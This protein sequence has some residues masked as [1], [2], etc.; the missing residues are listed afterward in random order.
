LI[1]RFDDPEYGRLITDL[2]LAGSRRGNYEGTIDGA[3]SRLEWI[4]LHGELRGVGQELRD[5]DS[6]DEKWLE[7]RW[8]ALVSKAREHRHVLPPKALGGKAR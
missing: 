4:R 2:Q 6:D 7:R 8:S 1:S 5:S 3:L